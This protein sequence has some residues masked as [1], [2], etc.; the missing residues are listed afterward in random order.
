MTDWWVPIGW[1]VC[2]YIR[3]HSKLPHNIFQRPHLWSH[4]SPYLKHRRPQSISIWC[5]VFRVFITM[6]SNK[7]SNSSII[8]TFNNR[9]ETWTKGWSHGSISIITSMAMAGGTIA[10]MFLWKWYQNMTI[11]FQRNEMDTQILEM[12]PYQIHIFLGT[13][14]GTDWPKKFESTELGSR[15]QDAMASLSS[16]SDKNSS[17]SSVPKCRINACDAPV[18]TVFVFPDRVMYTLQHEPTREE[19]T[20]IL[21]SHVLK[22][23]ESNKAAKSEL[24]QTSM[25][26]DYV[27]VCG[28]AA[29][30]SRCGYCGPKLSNVF[31]QEQR[32]TAQNTSY[33]VYQ[34]SHVGGH[35][36]AGN[37]IIFNETG[38]HWLGYVR[39]SDVPKLVSMYLDK[40]STSY[41]QRRTPRYRG[42]LGATKDEMKCE[43]E[44]CS[45][46]LDW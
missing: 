30:D 15:A 41:G 44:A 9:F 25:S 6:S 43:R 35:H 33:E 26:I 7:S 19:L 22:D 4:S 27:M 2:L 12:K 46:I 17:S 36:L 37:V 40:N 29:R 13:G 8:T 23:E 21:K 45:K 42:A 38:G 39:P 20:T 14:K 16:S 24:G 1:L 32:Q 3:F 5:R 10:A 31:R 18:G 28:H 11:G 34:C